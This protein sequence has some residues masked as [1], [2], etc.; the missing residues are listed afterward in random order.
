VNKKVL[1]FNPKISQTRLPPA[2]NAS[3]REAGGLQGTSGQVIQITF[4]CKVVAIV[5]ILIMSRIYHKNQ[6]KSV[7]PHLF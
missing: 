3:Q 6:G 1:I 4:N 5:S 7:C 2:R